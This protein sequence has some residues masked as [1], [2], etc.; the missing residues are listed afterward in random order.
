MCGIPNG[1]VGRTARSYE[2]WKA[3]RL[4]EPSSNQTWLA[5]KPTNIPKLNGSC[6]IVHCYIWLLEVCRACLKYPEMAADAIETSFPW[7]IL[8]A[9]WCP[10]SLWRSLGVNKTQSYGYGN[11]WVSL[12]NHPT[13]DRFSTNTCINMYIYIYVCVCDWMCIFSNIIR[14]RVSSSSA[15]GRS[16]KSMTMT[17][18]RGRDR[19]VDTDKMQ[20]VKSK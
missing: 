16:A 19:M 6:G 20:H 5:G 15:L 18:R 11:P 13:N 8:G 17:G 1:D 7:W 4:Q 10:P 12:K 2:E 9:K 3:Q 14:Y